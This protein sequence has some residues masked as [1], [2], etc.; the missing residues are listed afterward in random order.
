MSMLPMKV[1]A[2]VLKPRAMAAR[3]TGLFRKERKVRYSV[4]ATCA[5]HVEGS[6]ISSLSWCRMRHRCTST[7]PSDI[8]VQLLAGHSSTYRVIEHRLAKD[9][10]IQVLIGVEALE[11][12]QHCNLQSARRA[13]IS[14]HRKQRHQLGSLAL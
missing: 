10:C 4:I 1:Q 3:V 7:S 14:A 13:D 9:Q 5:I 6:A 8:A 11:D 12:R 2:K